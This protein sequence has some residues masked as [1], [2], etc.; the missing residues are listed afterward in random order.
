LSHASTS[1]SSR[2]VIFDGTAMLRAP[3]FAEL[4]AGQFKAIARV[5]PIERHPR[6]P[7]KMFALRIGQ[8]G[9]RVKRVVSHFL[10]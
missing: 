10:P 4:R 9:Q 3:R 6:Q 1:A 2:A 5:D 8:R 7:L